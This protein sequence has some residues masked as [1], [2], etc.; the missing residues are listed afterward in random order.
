MRRNP[1]S[2]VLLA[3]A[4]P[5]FAAGVRMQSE[6][7]DVQTGTVT[8]TEVLLD[9]TRLRLNMTG[10]KSSN[11]VLFLTDG[12]RDRMVMLDTAKNEYMEI[13]KATMDKMAQQF[14]GAM[15]QMEAMMAK[16]KPEQR[17]AMEKALK[18]KLPTASAA[19]AEKTVYSA[20][21]GSSVNGFSC[22]KYD[23][24]RG[25]AKVSEICAAAPSALRF[26]PTDF[27]VFDRMRDFTAPMMKMAA[28][29]PFGATAGFTGFT[30][31]GF[32]GIPVSHTTF[33]AGKPTT[34]TEVK[35]I[36]SASFSNSDFSLGSAKKREMPAMPA[37]K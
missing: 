33:S 31:P 21:G 5:L 24:T 19:P 6:T 11:S 34:K 13:D 12:G 10:L 16:M 3:G 36:K 17:A 25:G 32:S 37:P 2:I 30:D 18:G 27:Q 1:L 20:K 23:G 14:Q 4:L 9:Q 22:T 7:T 26:T 15:G 28:N 29:S 8:K 35:S